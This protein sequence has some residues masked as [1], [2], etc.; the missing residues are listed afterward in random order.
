MKLQVNFIE[1]LLET[2]HFAMDNGEYIKTMLTK[3]LVDF[4]I[5]KNNRVPLSYS[6]EFE[7]YNTLRHT[8]SLEVVDGTQDY[9]EDLRDIFKISEL[10]IQ[11]NYLKEE[12]E[13]K[14]KELVQAR[15]INTNVEENNMTL[16]RDVI[17]T[18]EKLQQLEESYAK[19]EKRNTELALENLEYENKIEELKTTIKTLGDM[20]DESLDGLV[21]NILNVSIFLEELAKESDKLNKRLEI[22]EKADMGMFQGTIYKQNIMQDFISNVLKNAEKL[23]GSVEC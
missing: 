4:I 12:L 23:G 10:T 16:L 13:E 7:D 21:N 22:F 8:L 20:Q 1:N 17:S 11:N 14:T 9:E 5:D 15:K 3:K 18:K 6:R 19:L 2:R